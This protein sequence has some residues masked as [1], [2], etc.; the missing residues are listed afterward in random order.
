MRN[1]EAVINIETAQRKTREFRALTPAKRQESLD[2]LS[3]VL[4]GLVASPGF[5]DKKNLRRNQD[6]LALI[7]ELHLTGSLVNPKK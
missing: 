4:N 1:P 7:L 2:I 6:F 3:E 5:R